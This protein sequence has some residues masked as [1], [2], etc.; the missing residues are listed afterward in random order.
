VKIHKRII[1]LISVLGMITSTAVVNAQR[2]DSLSAFNYPNFH[3]ID[4]S[5]RSTYPFIDFSKNNYRFYTD[6]SPSFS[7]LHKNLS[8]I[9]DSKKG[10]LNFYHIGGSHIQADIYSNEFR[11]HLQ[12]SWQK[13][14]GE[15]GWVFPFD[16][17]GTNNP[18]NYEFKSPNT[19]KPYR[20]IPHRPSKFDVDYGLLGAV[21]TCPDSV[22]TMHF[23]YDRTKSKPPIQKIRVYH[24]K[25]EFPYWMHFGENELL[26]ERTT[27]D[28]L[29]GMSEIFF[30][31][32]IDSFNLQFQRLGSEAPELEIY[33]FI[34]MNN[35]PGVSYTSI[36]INGAGLYTYLD[37]IRFEEQLKSYPP[38]F[39]AFS[40][41]TNDGNM[42]FADFDPQVYKRNLE[43][44]MQMVLR[45][46][47]NCAI[48]LTVPN[49]AFY[50]KRYLNQNIAREREVII[51][52]AVK[53]EMA[54]WD[55]YGI[56]GEL[57]SSRTW[58]NNQLMQSDLVHFTRNGYLLK[59]ELLI[60]AFL[61]YMEQMEK[62]DTKTAN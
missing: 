44:M 6:E 10:K 8:S 27:H 51:E 36:G 58:K 33:G 39:F 41:G 61:K 7:R 13:S 40:V 21:I 43:K 29:I 57:G 42:P 56:M 14:P 23:S 30:T 1:T 4:T 16:L 54:V 47:P 11:E 55:F 32:P 31:D 22:I 24:N 49:D 37:N 25:G 50:R 48:L 52:L 18:G 53:Y 35:L 12:T 9:K 5:Y 38:D 19:W 62:C 45:A 17:A 2:C 34:L 46:N 20:C 3:K 59:G 15:R 26:V 60:D 28:P